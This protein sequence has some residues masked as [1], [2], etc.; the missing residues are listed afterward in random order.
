MLLRDQQSQ[1]VGQ[2]EFFDPSFGK[3]CMPHPVV[4]RQQ[5]PLGTLSRTGLRRLIRGNKSSMKID[6][7]LKVLRSIGLK[8]ILPPSSEDVTRQCSNTVITIGPN[9]FS[10]YCRKPSISSA[11]VTWTLG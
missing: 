5:A 7:R 4:S 10:A 2:L 11:A 9:S 6:R 8:T 1:T 3:F